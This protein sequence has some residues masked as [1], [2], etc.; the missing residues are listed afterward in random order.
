MTD[1]NPK[2]QTAPESSGA[3]SRVPPP[4]PRREAPA[5][6]PLVNPNAAPVV[7]KVPPPASI[8]LTQLFWILS[9]A[10]GGFCIVYFFIIRKA[11]LP[12]IEDVMRGVVDGR[13]D[14]TYTAAADIV[15]WTVFGVMVTI[16]IIQIAL[17]VSFMSR[18]PGVRWWQFATFV[19]Q[20]VLLAI[21][22][23]L[24]AT[25]GDG[26]VLRQLLPLQAILVL[27]A[28]LVSTLPA[29]LRWT[30][31]GVDIRRGAYGSE[32]SEM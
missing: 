13:A 1:P 18:R 24:V 26:Q 30:A 3:V 23:E 2:G 22:L 14:E 29:G 11:Q 6:P 32:G 21:S 5:R 4:A 10:L 25:S 15:F 19:L 16:L 28:L 20:V 31:R 9:F 12:I 27:L 17:L 7:A 8:R